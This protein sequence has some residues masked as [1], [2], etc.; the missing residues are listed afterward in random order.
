MHLS[1]QLLCN[2]TFLCLHH[3][4]FAFVDFYLN[5]KIFTYLLGFQ[6]LFSNY[7]H[8]TIAGITGILAGL[9]YR[10]KIWGFDTLTFPTSINRFCS[11]Y[12][13]PFLQPTRRD[14]QQNVHTQQGFGNSSYGSHAHSSSAQ[15]VPSEEYVRSL[16]TMGFDRADAVRALTHSQN[17]LELATHLLLSEQN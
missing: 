2:I 1:L 17:N 15:G 12:L 8:S 14:H 13:A 7:P 10:A 3:L 6:L 4:D 16:T 5:D 11:R 9:I